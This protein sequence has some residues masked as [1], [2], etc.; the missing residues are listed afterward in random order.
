MGLAHAYELRQMI[1]RKGT[2]LHERGQLID[3]T[4]S[5]PTLHHGCRFA[6]R[7][8]N[9]S[10]R[11]NP[12]ANRATDQSR[13]SRCPSGHLRKGVIPHIE[14]TV[15]RALRTRKGCC[16]VSVLM[17]V[18]LVVLVFLAAGCLGAS[19]A[20]LSG[21][22]RVHP[23]RCG[24]VAL[25]GGHGW[26]TRS[27]TS[28]GLRIAEATTARFHEPAAVFPDTSLRALPPD[29]ILVMA[30]DF[31]REPR[32]NLSPT[33]RLPYQLAEFRHDRGWEGQPVIN[34]PQFVLFTSLRDHGLDVRVFFGRQNP[35]TR[36][37]AQAQ[38]ELA[39]LRWHL[40]PSTSYMTAPS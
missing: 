9:P 5:G 8:P 34:V 36:V 14:A 30:S 40:C 23:A 35:G 29:G 3:K 25:A 19:S 16:V 32:R 33:R 15:P 20:A 27:T 4:L 21:A 10:A 39:S 13:D 28:G 37:F 38:A 12:P 22:G 18:G 1:D 2:R 26:R 24:S 11:G 17:R 6:G 31:G 7:P